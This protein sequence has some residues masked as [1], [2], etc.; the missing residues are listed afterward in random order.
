MKRAIDHSTDQGVQ[1]VNLTVYLPNEAAVGIY[2]SLGFESH[3][4]EPD[5]VYL[6]ERYHAAQ[7]MTLV[8]AR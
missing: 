1:R 3:G 6:N 5:A 8:I 2:A 7:H 4:V